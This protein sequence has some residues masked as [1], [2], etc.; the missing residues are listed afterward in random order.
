VA[1]SQE[2]AAAWAALEGEATGQDEALEDPGQEGGN[3]FQV[4]K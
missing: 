3:K 1:L 2:L 4:P